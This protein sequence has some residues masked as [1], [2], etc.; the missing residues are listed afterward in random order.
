VKLTVETVGKASS[1]FKKQIQEES[2][3]DDEAVL[4][5][6]DGRATGSSTDEDN[7]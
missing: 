4:L 2:H 7:L 5:R 6:P 3:L 1:L